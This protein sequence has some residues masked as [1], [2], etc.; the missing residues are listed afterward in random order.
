MAENKT[1]LVIPYETIYTLRDLLSALETAMSSLKQSTYK[2]AGMGYP[3]ISHVMPIN[4]MHPE[5]R[6]CHPWLSDRESLNGGHP[7]H[8]MAIMA[9]HDIWFNDGAN[10]TR[11]LDYPCLVICSEETL[12]YAQAVNAAKED[13]KKKVLEIKSEYR[14]LT[15]NDVADNLSFREGEWGSEMSVK[16][17]FNQA[18]ITRICIK[19]VYRKIPLITDVGLLRA[20]Y[21][22]N[23]KQPSRK[24]TIAQQLEIFSTKVE[25]GI[26]PDSMIAAIEVLNGMDKDQVISERQAVN[27][28]MTTNYKIKSGT[29]ARW[30]QVTSVLPI[31]CIGDASYPLDSLVDFTSLDIDYDERNDR[32]ESPTHKPQDSWSRTSFLPAFR[33]FLPA[34]IK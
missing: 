11:T 19:Q 14:K 6:H 2:D 25:K 30:K 34:N 32:N 8:E 20:K 27:E 23:P 1:D 17:A 18:G 5:V 13:F 22:H 21:Y 9:I 12:C 24:R 26:A 4:A 16:Q 10:P 33:L 3:A 28:V 7:H 31:F 29:S 15:D